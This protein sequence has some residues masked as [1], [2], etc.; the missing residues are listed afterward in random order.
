LINRFGLKSS[1]TRWITP[2]VLI[3]LFFM[4][5]KN[6]LYTSSRLSN[7]NGHEQKP[8]K[9]PVNMVLVELNNSLPPSGNSS[10]MTV[11]GACW[12]NCS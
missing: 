6:R 11:P 12:L 5:S 2:G 8:S 9:V 3:V 4:M 7:C 1:E 10:T